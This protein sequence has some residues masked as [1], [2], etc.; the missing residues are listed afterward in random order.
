MKWVFV[1]PTKLFCYP[2]VA[3]IDRLTGKFHG[4]GLINSPTSTMDGV[5]YPLPNADFQ[6][7]VIDGVTLDVIVVATRNIACGD[8]ILVDY[9][10]TMQ[11]S[12]DCGG[13]MCKK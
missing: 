7:L 8:E 4:G 1:D 11:D 3:M 2:V 5:L 9:H 10:W 13:M 12:C 6:E